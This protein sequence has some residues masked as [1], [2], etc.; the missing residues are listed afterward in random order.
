MVFNS[1]SY[2]LFVP[3]VFALFLLAGNRW[4]WLVLLVASYVFYGFLQQPLLLAVLTLVI[5]L[6]FACGRALHAS[7]TDAARVRN[8]RIGVIANLA[9]LFYFKYLNFLALNLNGLLDLLH[10]DLA[11]AVPPV[12]VSIALSF[13]IFQAISYLADIYFG[14]IEP[15][16]HLGYFA[17][18][19]SFFPKLLQGPI[20]R[21]ADLLP[22]L[23]APYQTDYATL[24]AALI[25]FAWGLF[26]KLVIADRLATYVNPIYGNVEANSGPALIFA[27]Y[28]Y[29]LQIYFDFAGY[30]NMAL[31]IGRLFGIQLTPNFNSPYMATNVADFWRRW[32]MSFS[33]WIQDYVFVPLQMKFRN[34]GKQGASLALLITFTL[35]GIWHGAAW[36]YI[37]FGLLHGIYLVAGT[38]YRPYEKKLYKKYGIE[39]SNWVKY[40]QRFV[41][42]NLVTFAFIFFRSETL[43]D[44][45]YVLRHL[46]D[47]SAMYESMRQGM[48]NAYVKNGVLSIKGTTQLGIALFG[49][50]VVY[51]VF[52]RQALERAARSPVLRWA[53]YYSMVYLTLYCWVAFSN[54]TSFVYF[55]F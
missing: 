15:E 51:L 26:Q 37:V 35:A 31:G 12:L 24:R 3:L 33:R 5:L 7:K 48:L 25:L 28:A 13:F 2:L 39:K 41:T 40:W 32:H 34:L 43:S 29:V 1:L 9:I 4:K 53:G 47:F 46:F 44:A 49:L 42:F 52:K 6:T 14:M 10:A 19:I 20:E 27:T 54:S 50:L 55:N 38:Y 36:T 16:P 11:V 23:R 45:L 18:Y 22:Q 17:L 30:T 8:L 21:G